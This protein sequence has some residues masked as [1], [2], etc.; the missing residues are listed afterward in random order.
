[1]KSRIYCARRQSAKTVEITYLRDGEL[2]KTQLTTIS[3]AEFNDLQRAIEAS[4]RAILVL[5]RTERPRSP[6]R[7]QRHMACDW[8]TSNGMAVGSIWLESR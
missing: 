5:N 8:I 4:R 3:E 1:M 6:I 7:K 2:K